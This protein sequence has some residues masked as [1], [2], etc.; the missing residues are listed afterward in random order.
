MEDEGIAGSDD[1]SVVAAVLAGDRDRYAVLVERYQQR[2]YN[3]LWHLCGAADD[4]EELTQITF[5]RA[6]FALGSYKPEFKFS[7][8]LFQ[9]AHNLYLNERRRRRPEL[10]GDSST[11]DNDV[12]ADL[13]D[14]GA[15]PVAVV[16]RREA[17][18]AIWRAIAA[19]PDDYRQIILMRHVNELSYQE[20]SE[21]TCLPIGTVKSRLA[22]ARQQLAASLSRDLLEP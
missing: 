22:R 3:T 10:M 17:R 4:A 13:M 5:C 19:L 15:L 7:T 1:Q 11:A 6:Y 9:I 12:E 18:T 2:I 16:E 20:I 21:A 8:W 14:P